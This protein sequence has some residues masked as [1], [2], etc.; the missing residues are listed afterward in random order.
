M[1]L[2]IVLTSLILGL[3]SVCVAQSCLIVL[4]KT[5]GSPV[6]DASVSYESRLL[7]TDING[8]VC[9][10]RNGRISVSHLNYKSLEMEAGS[11]DSTVVVYLEPFDVELDALVI[12]A[13]FV[14]ESPGDASY[15]IS[16]IAPSEIVGNPSLNALDAIGSIAGVQLQSGAK[17]TSRLTIRGMGSRSPY[18]T[19]RIKA[20]FAGIPLSGGDGETEMDD[21]D[22]NLLRAVDLVK[23]G[24]AA[25][26]GNGLAGVIL[27]HP[28]IARQ[29]GWHAEA[30]ITAG[31]DDLIQ[32]HALLSFGKQ[33]YDHLIYG[34]IME[35]D[36]WRD[37][38]NYKRKTVYSM[39]RIDWTNWEL[40]LLLNLREYR[41][42]IP[43]SLNLEDY[44]NN[45]SKAADNW[46][47]IGGFEDNRKVLAGLGVEYKGASPFNWRS[48]LFYQAYDGLERRPF[49][50]LD[51]RSHRIGL[52]TQGTCQAG[53]LM[54]QVHRR[55]LPCWLITASFDPQSSVL[56]MSNTVDS[57]A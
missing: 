39:Q 19:N 12:K 56:C 52:V 57:K 42:S 23:G 31:S 4:D 48:S 11:S 40:S 27:L 28:V 35:T 24:Y 50:T 45:P 33:G 44:Q 25:L 17:N 51:D 43:S 21:I 13:A 22:R 49:N 14:S 55:I 32:S 30:G 41:A 7:Y 20:Y 5:N 6:S 37:N 15:R 10:E 2:R 38:D 36:G 26:Y 29:D 9:L 16:R 47:T 1:T 46:A 53:R 18:S 8:K 34:S 54:K 3:H